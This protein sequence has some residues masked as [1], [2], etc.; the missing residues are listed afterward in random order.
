MTTKK[1]LFG[2]ATLVALFWSPGAISNNSN[3]SDL[4]SADG[5]VKIL[6]KELGDK[7]KTKPSK[8]ISTELRSDPKFLFT[9]HELKHSS[10][11]TST[12]FVR[13]P[14]NIEKGKTLPLV[15]IAAGIGSEIN[16]F[17]AFPESDNYILAVFRY[18]RYP[19]EDL[20]QIVES[21]SVRLPLVYGQLALSLKWL[22][23]IPE[24]SPGRINVIFVSFS[25]F[26]GPFAIRLADSVIR[27]PIYSVVFAFG[28]AEIK[29]FILPRVRRFLSPEDYEKIEGPVTKLVDI[30]EP[31]RHL[32]EINKEVL[33][34]EGANDEMIPSASRRAL[35]RAV[36]EPKTVITLDA[37][38]IN[39]DRADIVNLTMIKIM[40]WY[41][42]QGALDRL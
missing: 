3:Y 1:F 14:L 19:K 34:I 36:R 32:R 40:D 42:T 13:K 37:P 6:L 18:P 21:T 4:I 8:I 12:L 5:A 35:V 33:I 23:E 11:D 38:H 39:M 27:E 17:N 15:F 30:F 10:L 9:K 24:V 2:L 7:A 41:E 26:V 22:S 31:K 28:G 20:R 16:I 25:T 29:N